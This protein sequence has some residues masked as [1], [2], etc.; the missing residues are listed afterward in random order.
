MKMQHI[1][2]WARSHEHSPHAGAV[3]RRQFVGTATG[4]GAFAAV[5]GSGAHTHALAGPGAGQPNPN[6]HVTPGPFGPLHFFFPGPVDSTD[7]NQGHDPSLI[8]DFNG[9]VGVCDVAGNAKGMNTATGV[10]VDD[11][12]TADLRFMSGVFIGTDG[13]EHKGTFAFV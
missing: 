8:T 12:Y 1:P 13:R 11:N 9:F 2:P 4:L 7:P 10:E 5:L 3:S 6:P